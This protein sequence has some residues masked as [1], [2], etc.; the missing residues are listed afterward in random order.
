MN[1]KQFSKKLA[2]GL[3][4]L[5][6]REVDATIQYYNE[7]I[8]DRMDEGDSEEKAIRSL[9]EMDNLIQSAYY[10]YSATGGSETSVSTNKKANKSSQSGG[11]KWFKICT[12]IIWIPIAITLALTAI[13][14]I[15]AL[16]AVNIAFVVATIVLIIDLIVNVIAGLAADATITQ[17]IHSEGFV[18]MAVGIMGILSALT[19]IC[20][21][22]TARGL[23]LVV[24][25]RRRIKE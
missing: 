8:N 4:S 11:I 22:F 15:V 13:I 6:R 7:I 2:K 12:S 17:I 20:S 21:K 3:T 14:I 24:K 1:K 5:P 10:N 9:G 19:T 25:G 18:L 23:K 16:F